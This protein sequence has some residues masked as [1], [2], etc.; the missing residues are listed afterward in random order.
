MLRRLT[1]EGAGWSRV[2]GPLLRPLLP[3]RAVS[4]PVL[5]GPAQGIRLAANLRYDAFYW[6]GTYERETQQALADILRPGEAFW[7]VGAHVGFFS[8]LAARVVGPAGHV[9][10]LEPV[11]ANIR[12]LQR[13]L[14]LNDARNVEIEATAVAAQSGMAR[15]S[16]H[17]RGAM[18]RLTREPDEAEL[19][20]PCRTLDDLAADRGGPTVVKIDV[21][22][23]ELDVLAG[24]R[25]LLERLRTRLLVEFHDDGKFVEAGRRLPGYSFQPVLERP[26]APDRGAGA[27]TV[28][29]CLLSPRTT[30]REDEHRT[31]GGHGEEA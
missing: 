29:V 21:E 16:P 12:L 20:V 31:D 14:R 13:S 9:L 30:T 18:W 11:P 10:A 24:A 27:E 28:R 1:A 19:V 5:T 22:G 3:D 23:A 6:T 15:M 4:L 8:L 7:D 17:R 2:A 25:Q 26:A